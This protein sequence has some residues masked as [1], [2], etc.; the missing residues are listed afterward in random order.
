M[1]HKAL[2]RNNNRTFAEVFFRDGEEGLIEKM[3]QAWAAGQGQS[4]RAPLAGNAREMSYAA[5]MEVYNRGQHKAC[6]LHIGDV[7]TCCAVDYDPDESSPKCFLDFKINLGEPYGPFDRAG[8]WIIDPWMNLACR[9]VDYHWHVS[10]KLQRWGELGKQ[11]QD[12][13]SK[14]LG[15]YS[16][17]YTLLREQT[18]CF[19]LVRQGLTTKSARR[20][21]G[22]I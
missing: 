16:G 21:Y 18:L 5:A 17:F 22:R 15:A 19:E 4:L 9:F 7:H 14:W 3:D 20:H 1:L 11:I 13:Q 10:D 2:R 8:A 6:L 12:S